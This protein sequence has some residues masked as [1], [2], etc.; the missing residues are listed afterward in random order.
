M[1]SF[2]LAGAVI[3]AAMA[4]PAAATE[5]SFATFTGLG[6]SFIATNTDTATGSL[7]LTDAS[8]VNFGFLATATMSAISGISA[9][10]VLTAV[11]ANSNFSPTA[12]SDGLAYQSGFNGSLTITSTQGI[13]I[14]STYY[15]AGSNLLTATFSDASLEGVLGLEDAG[16]TA[17]SGNGTVV[18][19]SDFLSFSST[20]SRDYSFAVSALVPKLT[21]GEIN[22]SPAYIESFTSTPTGSFASD[23]LPT[24]AAV[25]EPATWAMLVVGLGAI[26]LGLR[27]TARRGPRAA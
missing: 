15:A 7:T 22:G 23:P 14:G 27:G 4:V 5:T 3:A 2:A 8:A 21:A 17:D 1:R 12:A 20:F 16:L 9:N 6:V 25:P 10:M 26:G 18:Y 24:T 11:S 19:S 13:T